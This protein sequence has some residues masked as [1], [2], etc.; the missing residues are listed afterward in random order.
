MFTIALA[1]LLAV[2]TPS[3]VPPPDDTTRGSRPVAVRV[4]D[5]SAHLDSARR[6]LAAGEFDVAR[7]AFVIA[8]A[9]ERDAGRLP[10]EA[11]FGLAHVLYSQSYNREAAFTLDRLAQDAAKA[12]DAET[13]AKALMDATWLHVD[14]GQRASARA[15]G[16]RLRALL[17]E[18]RL[19]A[20]TR[21]AVRARVG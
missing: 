20:E 16:E 21:K 2:Q 18:G 6:A 1:A 9:L 17:K 19:S 5:A 4:T 8:A 13:E 3:L 11:A 10:I 15:C 14:A 7:R 12:G